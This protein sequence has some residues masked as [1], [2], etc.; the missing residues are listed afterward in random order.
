VRRLKS[1]DARLPAVRSAH[2]VTFIDERSAH[3]FNERWI[4]V[5][6][7]DAETSRRDSR[8]LRARN[9]LRQFFART[10]EFPQAS[11]VL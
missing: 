2:L 10:I 5:D 8:S 11:D 6:Q 7:Q 1:V 9:R 3:H 4:I